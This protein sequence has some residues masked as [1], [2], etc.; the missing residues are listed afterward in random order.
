MR[1][2]VRQR[3][4]FQLIVHYE[5]PPQ[6]YRAFDEL[7]FAEA[8]LDGHLRLME[9]YYYR[10]L[11]LREHADPTEGE[12][13]L[14][15]TGVNATPVNYS[16]ELFNPVYVLCMS[17]TEVE[18][19]HLTRTRPYVV[20]VEDTRK[21]FE[22]I[23]LELARYRD[24]DSREV[25]RLDSGCVSYDKGERVDPTPSHPER[26]RLTYLQKPASFLPDCESRIAVVMS[27]SLKAACTSFHLSIGSIRTFATRF[28]PSVA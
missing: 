13:R 28:V 22:A 18:W 26:E 6:L 4:R 12:A 27:G 15:V 10:A 14:T 3:W 19:A 16:G 17:R 9:R 24:P 2:V 20:L 1:E 25:F 21:F 23:E 8:F 5:L 11:E 7:R